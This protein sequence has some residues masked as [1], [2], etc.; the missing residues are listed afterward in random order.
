MHQL[1]LDLVLVASRARRCS[2][3]R[4]CA[5]AEIAPRGA[6]AASS[7]ASLT[8]RIASSARAHVDDFVRRGDAG[9]RAVAHLVQQVR[10]AAVPVAEQA[11]RREQRGAVGGE[12]GQPRRQLARSDAPRRSRRS[13]ARRRGRSESRPRSRAPRSCSRQNRTCR[14]PSGRGDERDHRLG[15]GKPGQV[16]EIAVVPVRIE[17]IAVARA[18]PAR[19]GTSARPPPA[20][21]AHRLQHGVAAR[22]VD[23]VGVVHRGIL[24]G[25][26]IIGAAALVPGKRARAKETI[27][28]DDPY[29]SRRPASPSPPQERSLWPTT[30]RRCAAA[31]KRRGRRRPRC[32][33]GSPTRTASLDAFTYVDAEAARAA[34]RAADLQLAARTDLGPLMGVPIALKD[35]YASD[36]MPMTAGSRVDVA[37]RAPREGTLVRALKRAGAIIVGK[38]R[39]TEFAFGTFN[40]TH[41][42]PRNPSRSRRAPH[43]RRL[44]VRFG[45]RAAAGLC[46]LAFGTDTGG[47]VRQPAALCGVAGFKAT[48][49]RLPMDGVFPLSPTFDSAGWFA[50]P[51]R[52]SRDRLAG[53]DRRGAGCTASARHAG[54]RPSRCAFLRR[55][56]RRRR[57]SDRDCATPAGRSRRADR[58]GDAAVARR[59]RRRVRRVPVG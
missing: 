22:A 25:K 46:A 31:P 58:A 30:A 45:G 53:A 19:S 13:R 56:R 32:S 50:Q 8:R 28:P 43:A 5:A 4:R 29:A 9:A 16:I 42:T 54:P 21:V 11:E 12:L 6:S 23:L 47:S 15:L 17:R 40:P 59:S 52:R 33:S 1:G 18:P 34:A 37:E 3:A 49:G 57:A 7:C 38:T 41:P 51:R 26:P 10:D 27:V 35:L 44:V 48:A 14:S 36:G 24:R 55:S 20:C 39:T 2:I